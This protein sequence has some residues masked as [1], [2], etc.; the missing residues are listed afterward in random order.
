MQGIR[1]IVFA[2]LLFGIFGIYNGKLAIYHNSGNVPNIVLPYSVNI[3]SNE[4]R[5]ALEEGIYFEDA[6]QL[7][8]LLEDFLS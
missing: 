8:T 3:F 2:A 1:A 5:A 7:S 4:D 6:Y